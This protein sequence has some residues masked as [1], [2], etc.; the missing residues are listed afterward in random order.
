MSVNLYP[1][2]VPDARSR[3]IKSAP[4][5]P[6]VPLARLWRGQATD[7]GGTPVAVPPEEVLLVAVTE[8][9]PLEALDAYAE[10][11][12][13]VLAGGATSPEGVGS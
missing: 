3:S 11:A 12:A 4:A 13:A 1:S 5:D 8:L 6:G 2:F 7:P 10:A 9:N